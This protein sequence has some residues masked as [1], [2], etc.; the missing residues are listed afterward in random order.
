MNSDRSPASGRDLDPRLDE[1]IAA[2][3]APRLRIELDAVQRMGQ[4]TQQP[5]D[6]VGRRRSVGVK[7]DD[8]ARPAQPVDIAFAQGKGIGQV[9]QNEAGEFLELAALAFPAHPAAFGG[10]P[11]APPVEQHERRMVGVACVEA[12][13]ASDQSG[14]DQRILRHTFYVCVREVAQQRHADE[15]IGVRQPM[16]LQPLDQ[17]FNLGR[18][19]QDHRHHQGR[20]AAGA[21]PVFDVELRQHPGWDEPGDDPVRERRR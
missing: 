13:H 1:G 4:R 6:A 18:L 9:A 19:A 15:R 7:R 11:A 10:I 17:R 8:E 5:V 12:T 2:A 3:R 14:L 20:V 16:R 21:Q